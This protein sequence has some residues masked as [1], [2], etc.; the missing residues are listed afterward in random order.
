[1]SSSTDTRSRG[2]GARVVR[3]DGTPAPAR[4]D[5]VDP[6]RA[7]GD[8]PVVEAHMHADGGVDLDPIRKAA[9]AAGERAGRAEGHAAGY[10]AGLAEG[11][12]AG[13]AEGLRSGA[14]DGRRAMAALIERATAAV[15]GAAGEL[16]RRDAV[17]LGEVA[18]EVADLAI[19]LAAA[20]LEREVAAATDPGRDAL[21]RALALA[22]DRG[23]VLA[24]LHPDDAAGLGADPIDELAPGRE[25]RLVADPTV[26]VG[27]CVIEVG[28]CR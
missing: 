8:L 27:G 24:R 15:A 18:D 21:A 11:L 5:T 13:R 19:G 3:T 9:W 23:P 2:I 6:F 14:E 12:A 1:M 10:E 17:A 16:A 7:V 20:I 25:L 28:P 4:G 22:P 26:G